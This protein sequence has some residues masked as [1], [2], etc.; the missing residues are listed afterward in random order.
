MAW[1]CGDGNALFKRSTKLDD[2]LA[3]DG[4]RLAHQVGSNLACQQVLAD[5]HQGGVG[6]CTDGIEGVIDSKFEPDL[7]SAISFEG[8]NHHVLRV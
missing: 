4:L 5:I 2:P 7:C 3:G 6:R 8:R 1:I